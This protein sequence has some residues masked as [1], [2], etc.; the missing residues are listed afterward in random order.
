MVTPR[1]P[2][3]KRGRQRGL[4][5][6]RL[7][8]RLRTRRVGRQ[9][10]ERIQSWS[11]S[12]PKGQRMTR[13]W[14]SWAPGQRMKVQR[15]GAALPGAPCDGS[16]ALPRREESQAGRSWESSDEGLV[17]TRP[18]SILHTWRHGWG[19][20]AEARRN[21]GRSGWQGED[22]G[23]EDQTCLCRSESFRNLC[24]PHS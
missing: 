8:G 19:T 16:E 13:A 6:W 21:W 7:P 22:D 14:E 4:S 24:R 11:H 18:E 23:Q 15:A 20:E 12:E 2:R 10:G 3:E 5:K 1:P 9:L 17:S